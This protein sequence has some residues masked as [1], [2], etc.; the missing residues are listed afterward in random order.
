MKSMTGFGAVEGRLAGQSLRVEISSVNSRKGLDLFLNL[1]REL[2]FCENELRGLLEKGISRG[3]VQVSVQMGKAGTKGGRGTKRNLEIDQALLTRYHKELGTLARRLKLPGE[4]S[5]E[6]LL[7]LPG[8]MQEAE[9]AWPEEV[10]TGGLGKL[11]EKALAE[12]GKSREREGA[13]LCQDLL[14]RLAALELRMLELK[15]LQPEILLKHREALK[16]KLEEAGLEVA[17]E[18]ERL[19]KE[20]VLFS[21]RCDVSEELTRLQ[22]HVQEARRLLKSKAAIGRNLDFLVQEIG[23]EINTTGSKANDIRVS[24][25]VVEMKTELEKVRE[26]VQNLE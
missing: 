25:M 23:R 2:A 3:R 8:V 21:D 5:L 26:Q 14:E 12:H 18:D 16:R 11:V 1:P 10:G 22:A 19:L 15:K 7:K 9:S 6:F 20:M 13:H 24:K 17:L 4:L